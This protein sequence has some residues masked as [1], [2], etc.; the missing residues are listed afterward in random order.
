M[1]CF[2]G[3]FNSNIRCTCK[4]CSTGLPADLREYFRLSQEHMMIDHY[5]FLVEIA[6]AIDLHLSYEYNESKLKIFQ[7]HFPWLLRFTAALYGTEYI[8]SLWHL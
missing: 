1:I 3:C 2:R 7:I 5:I 4:H 6:H 8:T